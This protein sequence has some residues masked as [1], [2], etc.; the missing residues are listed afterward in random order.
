MNKYKNWVVNKKNEIADIV[1]K[2]VDEQGKK[3]SVET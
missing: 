2:I 1:N 3:R